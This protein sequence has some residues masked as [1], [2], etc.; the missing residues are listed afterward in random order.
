[1]VVAV[2]GERVAMLKLLYLPIFLSLYLSC[3]DVMAVVW[4]TH[5][6]AAASRPY[7]KNGSIFSEALL[8]IVIIVPSPSHVQ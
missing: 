6:A 5:A 4:S 7:W 3:R 2:K 1:M 8:L